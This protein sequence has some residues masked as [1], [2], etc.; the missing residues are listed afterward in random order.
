MTR[1]WRSVFWNVVLML[2]MLVFAGLGTAVAFRG[3]NYVV[4]GLF[5][6]LAIVFWVATVRSLFLGVFAKPHGIVMRGLTRTTTIPWDEVEEITAGH[7]TGTAAGAVGAVAPVVTH[8]RP[9]GKVEQVEL[10]VVGGYGIRSRRPTSA[11]IAVAGLRDC[12]AD[13]RKRQTATGKDKKVTG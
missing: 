10:N 5:G 2:V 7:L 11:E 8:R 9:S 4:I 1:A 13:W 3:P 12:W 6:A